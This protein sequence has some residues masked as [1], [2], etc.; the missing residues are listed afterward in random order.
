MVDGERKSLTTDRVILVP[1]PADEVRCVH[2]VYRLFIEKRMTF[3]AISR[4]LNRQQI[5][6]VDGSDWNPSAVQTILTHP[7]YAGCNVFGR[8]TRRLYTPEKKKPMSEWTVIRRAFEPLVDPASYMKVQEMIQHTKDALPRNRSD[9]D[10]LDARP[11]D[12]AGS[13]SVH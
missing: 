6:Y 8:T 10:L 7:K 12:Y 11:V 2:E 9:K 1:G 13:L 5:K 4:E 3:A